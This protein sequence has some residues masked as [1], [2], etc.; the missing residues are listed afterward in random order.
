M[1]SATRIAEKDLK[2]RLRDR[3]FFIMGIITPLALAYIFHLVFGNAFSAESLD[4]D[5]G[6]VD[7]DGSQVSQSLGQVLSAMDADGIIVLSEFDDVAAAETAVEE[8]DV[9]A[10]IQLDPGLGEAAIQGQPYAIHVVGDVD[11]PT[12]TQV[13]SSIASEFGSAIER[14]QLSVATAVGVGG[15]PPP[16]AIAVWG[17]EA[18]QRPPAFVFTDISAETRQLDPN[19]FYA[20][21][22]AV[23]FLFFTVQF[24][25]V[26]ILEEKQE[27]TLSRLLAA[28]IGRASIVAAKGILS[29]ALGLI[30]M[31]V[32]IVATHYLMDALWGP[33]LGVALLVVTGVLAATAIM[34]LVAA[35]ATSAD[36]AANLGAIIAV[37]LGM[38]GGTFFPIGQGNDFLARLSRL[39]PHY[40]FMR[41]L[42]D[43]SGGADWTAALPA[44]GA[45]LLFSV[46]FGSVAW[47]LLRKK[48][49]G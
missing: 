20:A 37:I 16:E 43:I 41:G 34:G 40:W 12:S 25:V 21:G 46:V 27:G 24:G 10:F 42:S 1:G 18:A 22:M 39:T 32:L 3:S 5:V 36:G 9:G 7:L 19:T 30:S 23:F 48:L 13:A 47:V 33:P 45:L 4:L 11:S 6:L 2:L 44:A 35:N 31:T 29:F 15:T 17:Q 49:A 14:A 28:P 26:G 8:G 38:L